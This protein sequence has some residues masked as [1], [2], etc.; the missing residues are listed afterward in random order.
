MNLLT[1]CGI[2]DGIDADKLCDMLDCTDYVNTVKN[3]KN[4]SY[5]NQLSKGNWFSFWECDII[6]LCDNLYQGEK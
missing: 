4:K 5:I 3:R 6:P 2:K 1:Y